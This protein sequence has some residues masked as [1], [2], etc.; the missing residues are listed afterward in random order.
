[1]KENNYGFALDSV[2]STARYSVGTRFGGP[3]GIEYEYIHYKVGAGSTTCRAGHILVP[4]AAIASVS[5]WAIGYYTADYSDSRVCF[6]DKIAV[7][8]C[9]FTTTDT[10][11]LVQVAGR[12]NVRTASTQRFKMGD[13]VGTVGT[14]KQFRRWQPN[15]F[16]CFGQVCT[17]RTSVSSSTS[18]C[19]VLLQG[20][21]EAEF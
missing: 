9:V 8:M 2:D 20:R 1:M 12:A 17:A 3:N 4:Y 15:T 7:S 18:K 13:Y 11:G 10:Y 21:M 14:D 6:T 16:G 5:T 19:V